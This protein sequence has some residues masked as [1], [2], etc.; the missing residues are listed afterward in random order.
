[1]IFYLYQLTLREDVDD[2]VPG[3][4]DYYTGFV[5]RARSSADARKL[6]ASKDNADL[7]RHDHAD[8]WLNPRLTKCR[9]IGVASPG[10]RQGLAIIATEDRMH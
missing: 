9:K 2:A 3:F 1:M 10:T 8:L 6:A 7:V 4:Y 5:I